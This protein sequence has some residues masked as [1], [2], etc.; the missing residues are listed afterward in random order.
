[1]QVGENVRIQKLIGELGA[2]SIRDISIK[3]S[4]I[5]GRKA[6]IFSAPVSNNIGYTPKNQRIIVLAVKV[7]R[8]DPKIIQNT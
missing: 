7:V 5:C 2:N 8:L 6:Q 3:L 1:M 4:I